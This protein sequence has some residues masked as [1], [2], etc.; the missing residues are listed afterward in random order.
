MKCL[1]SFI[2]FLTILF[3]AVAMASAQ[4]GCE[5]KIAGEWQSTAP[6]ESG[7]H[8]YRFTPDG[9]VAVFDPQD[10]HEHRAQATAAFKLESP[11][12]PK[13]PKT[14]EFKPVPGGGRFPWGSGKLE[15]AHFDD[16]RFTLV[17]S[18]SEPAEWTRIDSY[19]Y[20]VVFAA[21]RGTP[22][23]RGGPAFGMLIKTGG[24]ETEIESFGLYYRNDKFYPGPLLQ[25][26]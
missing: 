1:F 24:K 4:A 3:A 10:A 20:F 15:V 6:G 22:P 14:L 9:K 23:H 25:V 8:I 17:K 7:A 11:P 5:F 19:G 2:S 13:D 16:G 12:D 26:S 18:G 21:H